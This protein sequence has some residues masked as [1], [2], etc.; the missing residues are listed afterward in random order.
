MQTNKNDEYGTRL[1]NIVY[2]F[3]LICLYSYAITRIHTFIS[4]LVGIDFSY[5]VLPPFQNVG[6]FDFSRFIYFAMYLDICYIQMHSKHYES[7]KAKTTYI[8]K[9]REYNILPILRPQYLSLRYV[10]GIE[11][12]MLIT[13]AIRVYIVYM[14]TF[15]I[16]VHVGKLFSG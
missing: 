7:R 11:I 10:F 13:S 16:V 14:V 6:R 4:L 8:L 9:R 5:Q 2:L 15:F 1:T 3:F 12:Y